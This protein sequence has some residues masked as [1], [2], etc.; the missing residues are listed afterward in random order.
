M[1]FAAFVRGG[2][3][4]RKQFA[5]LGAGRFG[6]SMARTLAS[7][8][9]DV[10]VVDH[11]EARINAIAEQVTHAL[12]M[13][14]TDEE[15]IRQ[16]GLSNFDVVVVSI[17]N[18]LQ[19]SIMAVVLTKEAGAKTVIA[20]ATD[21]LHAKILQKVGA[22]KIVMPEKDMGARLAQKLVSNNVLD[23]IELSADYCFTDMQCPER[24]V[25][26]NLRQL[27]LRG[28]YG[29][30]VVALCRESGR[31]DISPDP[32]QPLRH[33]DRLIMIAPKTVVEKMDHMLG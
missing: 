29:A 3:M 12:I 16:L 8:G 19:S 4:A 28:R 17:G 7:M 15:S 33:G 18:D 27:D 30:N 22:D 31:M 11:D 21:D 32:N 25:G 5:I 9:H 13:D 24:W 6:A 1:F 20:K 2:K 23:F 14:V 26:K 10:L